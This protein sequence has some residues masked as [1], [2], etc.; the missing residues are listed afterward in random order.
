MQ[1]LISRLTPIYFFSSVR[2]DSGKTTIVSNLA[3]Y[4]I[5]LGYKVAV[6][7]CDHTSS[8]KLQNAF[9]ESYD[10]KTYQDLSSLIK[11]DAPRFQ[12]NLFLTDTNKLSIFPGYELKNISKLF[13]DAALKNFFSQ[14]CNIFD[15]LLINLSPGLNQSLTVSNLLTKSFLWRE[16]KASSIIISL[17]DEKSLTSLDSF[18]QNN[19]II[20]YQAEENTYFIFNKV[21]EQDDFFRK[22]ENTLYIS[23]IRKLFNYPLTYIIP[24][25]DELTEQT[26]SISS[27][28]QKGSI[29][30]Q[31]IIGL[32]RTL[33]GS[34]TIN[35]L[36]REANTY[37][38]CISGSLLSKIYP[39]IEKLQQKVASKFFITPEDVNIYVEQN[40]QN[41]RIRIRLTSL[42]QKLLG[43]RADIPDYQKL[44]YITAKLPSKFEPTS[45]KDK[46]RAVGQLERETPYTLSF[47][48][49]FSFDDSFYSEPVAQ[50]NKNIPIEPFKESFPSPIIINFSNRIPEIPTLSNILGLVGQKKFITFNELPEEINKTGV[51]PVYIPTDFPLAFNLDAKYKT[52]FFSS[53]NF[54]PIN[55]SIS[56]NLDLVKAY[57]YILRK[58][59]QY[60]IFDIF[61]RNKKFEFIS[62]FGIKTKG[63]DYN[64]E[65]IQELPIGKFSLFNENLIDS[66]TQLSVLKE[67]ISN[68]SNIL[69]S[70][71]KLDF[72]NCN[73]I[74]YPI[75]WC[76]INNKKVVES[77]KDYNLNL[78]NINKYQL[79]SKNY[80]FSIN[81]KAYKFSIDT[82]INLNKIRIQ[83][84]SVINRKFINYLTPEYY[85]LSNPLKAYK[86]GFL[87]KNFRPLPASIN[88]D[89]VMLEYNYIIQ[90][91][92]DNEDFI[93]DVKRSGNKL[94][95][96]ELSY[97]FE[98][99]YMEPDL[100][101]RRRYSYK[102]PALYQLFKLGK[103][104]VSNKVIVSNIE[105][106]IAYNEIFPIIYIPKAI[107]IT[108]S[109]NYKNP[110][111]LKSKISS[112]ENNRF[113]LIIKPL[114]LIKENTATFNTQLPPEK[115]QFKRFFDIDFDGLKVNIRNIAPN[116]PAFL[117][118]Y[119]KYP[120][121][122][123]L[124]TENIN[125]IPIDNILE[126]KDDSNV[127]IDN[128]FNSE[129]S[130]PDLYIEKIRYRTEKFTSFNWK[131]PSYTIIP[132]ETSI[133]G[134]TPLKIQTLIHHTNSYI[135]ELKGIGIEILKYPLRIKT[136]K[137]INNFTN[138]D[139][140]KPMFEF[141]F[142]LN[143]NNI[144]LYIL[145]GNCQRQEN[146]L[147]RKPFEQHF[148]E[149][150]LVSK[151]I[152]KK[153][154]IKLPSPKLGRS[155]FFVIPEKTS[156]VLYK[157]LLWQ[158]SNASG[159]T[160]C[161]YNE[162]ILKNDT[163]NYTNQF[164]VNYKF[165]PICSE[166]EFLSHDD[167]TLKLNKA[168]I[169]QKYKIQNNHIKD[170]LAL[171]KAQAAK[172]STLIKPEKI[173]ENQ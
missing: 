58:T 135:S 157:H 168:F 40:E 23:D 159:P 65:R 160:F 115:P 105:Y 7:D 72:N 36:I 86:E 141:S 150:K 4:L 131:K 47:K 42:G 106:K 102:K 137:L 128:T 64:F 56:N 151:Y 24:I 156:D 144:N 25:I 74:G 161:E 108:V 51:S 28:L 33:G 167:I 79:Y 166:V 89:D 41:F 12:Q 16:C 114:Q 62:D 18:I 112:H 172:V 2:A 27:V 122:P 109:K 100:L 96:P 92:E 127:S 165:K 49:V 134:R 146:A 85:N 44:N 31:H 67:S 163:L 120:K 9:P 29:I 107:E 55:S 35:Y 11:A 26:D 81:T 17:P 3:V 129:I 80:A 136:L 48:S 73:K 118:N 22:T 87:S 154:A 50:V 110:E 111:W 53:N 104:K 76:Y 153:I 32:F 45:L 30:N 145:Q 125:Q 71:F 152:L 83:T 77:P 99:K 101:I 117:K 63:L 39:Y 20:S 130:K 54:V 82:K 140:L 123:L 143:E 173:T 15:Y 158:F 170:L 132:V 164:N 14:L 97:K 162:N 75:F 46:F 98:H 142:K 124:G 126:L 59:E 52:V 6:I 1:R 90:V 10:T 43:I 103:L 138:L 21:P 93:F 70:K 84:P 155:K 5:S 13:T 69:I 95:K 37:H 113:K 119:L 8:Q 61:A 34:A 149:P 78:I 147:I 169:R 57:E 139:D 66:Q 88:L 68:I 116:K 148:K 94:F 91:K 60:K 171:A 19:Q 121:L 38:S 133:K